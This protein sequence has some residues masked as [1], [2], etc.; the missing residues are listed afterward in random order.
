[1]KK[2]N[3]T[4][5]T[6]SKISPYLSIDEVSL[7]DKDIWCPEKDL[8]LQVNKHAG[9]RFL[10]FS[11]I[12]QSWLKTRAKQYI[13]YKRIQRTKFGT[14]HGYIWMFNKLSKLINTESINSF[15]DINEDFINLFIQQ[16]SQYSESYRK[17][18]VT[19]L[20]GFLSAGNI[21]GWFDIPTYSLN[22][23]SFRDKAKL[24]IK[25]IP[26]E[27]L[28]ELDYNL[29]LFP[30]PIQRLVILIR[31]LGLRGCEILQLK[32]DCLRQR[33][34]SKWEIEFTNWKFKDRLDR[35]PINDDLVSLIKQQQKYIQD[36]LGNSFTYLFC[37]N[38]N[39][40]R[41]SKK[42][43]QI[44]VFT[45]NPQV[46]SLQKFNRY[47]NKL[48]AHCSIKDKT[49]K[50]WHF[51]SHQFRR[52]VATKMTNEQVRQYIIQCYLRHQSPDMLKH[53]AELLPDTIKQ[54]MEEF[55]QKKKIVDV[56]GRE[57]KQI[58]QE[59]D[60]NIGLEWLRAKMQPK[61]LAMGF[62]ARPALLKPCPHANACMGCEHFRLD[63]DDLPALKQHLSR[64]QKLK[65]E[66]QKLGYIRQIKAVEQ[67][68]NRLT[69]I[70]NSLEN[71]ND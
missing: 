25:Y 23:K 13:L 61:A 27:V 8:G 22:G 31:T 18:N 68:E 58:H 57:V 9:K 67:D 56:T 69:I 42:R 17:L 16:V 36:N 21:E 45:P 55:R 2:N 62:C 37:D 59:L 29:H 49:G 14:L 1:M 28:K 11:N 47:L 24:R 50:Q 46:L 41:Y 65:N 38:K 19:Y 10:N 35:L 7:L 66:S 43:Q 51:T 71:N 54:E 3:V 4:E 5:K 26:N 32:F 44:F 40:C 33:R 20:K 53:Y 48:S 39:R 63:E 30:E 12:Q 64:S 34:N 60:N 52:T 15:S 6:V 70:I